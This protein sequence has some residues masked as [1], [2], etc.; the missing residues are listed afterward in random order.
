MLY[1]GCRNKAQD[2]IYQEEL[3]GWEEDGLLTLYTAFSRDQQQKRYVTHCLKETGAEVWQLLE[4]GAHLYVCGDAKMMAKD[5]R[6]IILD[7]CKND[8]GMDEKEAE[9][10]VKKMESQKR[11]SADVWS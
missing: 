2:Y 4:Q 1:F 7:I 8:G 10:F 6:N 11:Y 3:E 5:V 9:T